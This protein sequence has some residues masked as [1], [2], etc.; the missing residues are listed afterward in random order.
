MHLVNAEENDGNHPRADLSEFHWGTSPET[1]V[2]LRMEHTEFM[3]EEYPDREWLYYVA[4]TQKGLAFNDPSLWTYQLQKQLAYTPVFKL[5]PM[6]CVGAYWPNRE[7]NEEVFR[8]WRDILL[9]TVTVCNSLYG[10][11]PYVT[12]SPNRK[13]DYTLPNVDYQTLDA[14]LSF[15][16]ELGCPGVVWWSWDK[17]EVKFEWWMKMLLSQAMEK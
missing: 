14:Q 13:G 15:V 5:H 4:V 2:S 11:M 3:L 8:R 12:L 6:L 16:K 1:A 7:W 9:Y 10:K 17:P